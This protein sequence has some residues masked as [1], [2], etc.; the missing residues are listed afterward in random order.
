MPHLKIHDWLAALFAAEKPGAHFTVLGD[1]NMYWATALD[2]RGINTIH[3]RHEHCA[4][5]MALSH[6]RATGDVGLASVTCGPGLTHAVSALATAVQA[7]IPAVIFAGESPVGAHWYTQLID[8][9]PVVAS[10]GAT[11]LPIHS[12]KR[13][14]AVVQQAF[15][16]ARS[17]QQPV[18]IGA[19]MDLQQQPAPD[20][21]PVY[22]TSRDVLPRPARCPAARQSIAHAVQLIGQARRVVVIA[23]RGAVVSGCHQQACSL[24]QCTDALVGTSL[25][26][27]GFFTG[28]EYDLGIV[29]GYAGD[30]TRDKLTQADLVIT[31]GASLSPHM[32][33]NGD[34]FP[35]TKIIQIDSAPRPLSEGRIEADVYLV[36]DA[37]LTLDAL[38]EAMPERKAEPD[39]DWRPA[40]PFTDPRERIHDGAEFHI[41]DGALDPRKAVAELNKVLPAHWHLVNG[42]GH[43]A[44]FSAHMYGRAPEHFHTIR[45]YGAIGNCIAYGIG[46]ASAHP[47]EPVV[48]I[49]GDG[50]FMMHAQ[51]LET[52]KR[53]NLRLLVCVLNDGAYG[54]EIHKLRKHGLDERGALFGRG[55][56]GAIARGFGFDGRV[57]TQTSQLSDAFDAFVA[58]PGSAVWDIHVSDQ[59]VSPT[60]RRRMKK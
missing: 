42:A 27:R 18:V 36:G 15:M 45:E 35:N 19:P 55:D 50:G 8:Q 11:Y 4:I 53:H 41:E 60:M 21:L 9:G 6:A 33:E 30:F 56:L 57:I 28:H 29:G 39:Q 38:L 31:I 26:A 2:N 52:A 34:L 7:R 23:G 48:V 14:M 46:V 20:P 49:D 47:N 3:A 17:R 59:V 54:A 43:S 40:T 32:T 13:V 22:A 37:R 12:I 51:E 16:I 1:G 5:S 25:L 10:T 58:G 24:A 44:Y